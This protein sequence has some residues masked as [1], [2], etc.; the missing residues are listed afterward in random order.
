M[1]IIYISPVGGYNKNLFP[2]FYET[3]NANGHRWVTNVEEATHCFVELQIEGNKYPPEFDTLVERKIPIIC[4]DSREYGEGRMEDWQ[5]V[6]FDPNIYFIR[7]MRKYF[8]YPSNCYPFDWAVFRDTDF[9]PTTKEEL[10]AREYDVAFLGTM[11]SKARENICIAIIKD[12][13]LKFNYQDRD[14]TKRFPTYEQ[15]LNEHRKAKLY[16]SCDGSGLT[17]ERPMQLYSI[18]A[19]LKNKSHLRSANP[20]K[21]LINCIEINYDPTVEDI[22]K[23]L[24]V[25]EDA[26]WLYDIYIGG[27]N[28]ARTHLSHDAVSNYVLKTL[29][30]NNI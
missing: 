12:G 3:F 22:D 29:S 10:F 11:S 16:L 4:F 17:N 24:H 15:F 8:K 6:W 9:P 25:V 20:Y 13:R 2:Y 28:H 14:H 18:A 19:M 27:I 21:D 26:E 5:P 1:N 7:N 23:I 30:G